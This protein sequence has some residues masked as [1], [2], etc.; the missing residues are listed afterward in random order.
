MMVNKPI[1]IKVPPFADDQLA[2]GRYIWPIPFLSFMI[3]ASRSSISIQN[4]ILTYEASCFATYPTRSFDL[5]NISKLLVV[6]TKYP[7][8][9]TKELRVDKKSQC[10]APY[11]LELFVVNRNR[12]RHILIPSFV[13]TGKGICICFNWQWEK[14]LNKIK[15]FTDLPLER[16]EITASE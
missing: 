12:E 5:S 6:S 7:I 16:I 8:I 13:D 4:G 14:F 15:F 11:Y 1:K 10:R 2:G 3:G 9:F